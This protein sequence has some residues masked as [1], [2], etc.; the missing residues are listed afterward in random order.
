MIGSS[1]YAVLQPLK[2][3]PFDASLSAR[4]WYPRETNPY[5]HLQAVKC[6]N[7]Y[8]CRLNS[9][10]VDGTGD[11]PEV[12]AVG[13]VGLVLHRP[14]GQTKWEQLDARQSARCCN[15]R[16]HPDTRS[17]ALTHCNAGE[18]DCRYSSPTPVATPTPTLVATSTPTPA[19]TPRPAFPYPA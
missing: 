6:A 13:N 9:V 1:V 4:L 7:Q 16:T 18:Q 8:A 2:V 10:A 12:W 5:V 17:Q 14:A 11:L 3:D 19:A 15:T